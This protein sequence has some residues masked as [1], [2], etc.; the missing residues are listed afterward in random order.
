MST[1]HSA[2]SVSI[3]ADERSF[4]DD[5]ALG[6]TASP[7]RLP[8]RYLY[9]GLGS[10]LFDAICRL[11]WYPLTR[12]EQRLLHEHGSDILRRLAPLARVIELGP[13][14]GEKLKTLLESR[15]RGVEPLDVHLIDLSGAALDTAAGA[16]HA[17]DASLRLLRHENSYQEGLRRL[18]QEPWIGGR[19]LAVFLGSNIGNFDPADAEALLARV[20]ETLRPGDA[21]LLGADLVRPVADLLVAYDDPLGVTAAFNRNLLVRINRELGGNFRLE[22]FAHAARWNA[23]ASRAE[24]HL[25]SLRDQNVFV[26]D[27]GIRITLARD[28]TIWTESSHKYR[29]DEVSSLL[30]RAGFRV[31]SQWEEQF[32][33]LTLALV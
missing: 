19:S 22:H 9:D 29:R 26:R 13:G 25:V 6:L 30:A 32:F 11:P 10:A 4:A 27:A 20:R 1:P 3:E 8:T 5:V 21:L 14:N 18:S 7:R 24:M 17:A 28:E 16:L 12:A 2:A 23:E 15:R 33:T 31:A